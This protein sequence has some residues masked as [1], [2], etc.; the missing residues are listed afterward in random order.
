[1]EKNKYGRY[2]K[3]EKGLSEE[4]KKQILG[5]YCEDNSLSEIGR[6]G[7]VS[8]RAS[9]KHVI[10]RQINQLATEVHPEGRPTVI[11]SNDTKMAISFYKYRQP[12]ITAV[13]IRKKLLEDRI[14]EQQYLPS[15]RMITYTLKK[16]SYTRKTIQTVPRE[17]ISER[18][19]QLYNEYVDVISTINPFNLHFC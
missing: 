18:N 14:C 19:V 15:D 6:R 2:Y 17:G 9:T 16:L 13:E 4:C 3:K 11:Y 8:K 5:L 10:D 7:G 1:M 12:S